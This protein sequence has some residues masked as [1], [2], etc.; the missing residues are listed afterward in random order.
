[1]EAE[2]FR[3]WEMY[4][5]NACNMATNGCC[6]AQFLKRVKE[7]NPRLHFVDDVIRLY[8]RIGRI[9]ERDD[10]KDLKSIGAGFNISL[11]ML[12]DR[13]ARQPIIDRLREAG[14]CLEQVNHIIA[15]H[16]S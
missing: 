14:D 2:A 9:W 10:G 16:M 1:M 5:S 15:L 8:E 13:N 12:K 3:K 7:L 4:T 6:A 11:E